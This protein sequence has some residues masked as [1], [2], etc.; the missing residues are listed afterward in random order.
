[1]NEAALSEQSHQFLTVNSIKISLK[2]KMD[3]ELLRYDT[4][5]PVAHRQDLLS[6]GLYY[7]III[8]SFFCFYYNYLCNMTYYWGANE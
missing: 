5:N 3:S 6:T 1:V 8:E 7:N 4:M 2:K